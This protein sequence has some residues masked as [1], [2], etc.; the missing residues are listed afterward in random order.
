M[1]LLIFDHFFF[2]LTGTIEMETVKKVIARYMHQ[3]F[4]NFEII[5]YFILYDKY[6]L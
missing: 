5:D 1:E 2:F 6:F 3:V 4:F